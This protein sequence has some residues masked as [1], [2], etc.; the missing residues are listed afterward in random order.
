MPS[1]GSTDPGAHDGDDGAGGGDWVSQA[2]VARL[3]LTKV[4]RWIDA[5]MG[6]LCP[7]GGAFPARL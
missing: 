7:F 3:R 2:M 5:R 4:A 6:Q 1:A